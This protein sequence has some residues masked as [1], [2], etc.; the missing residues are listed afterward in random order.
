[1]ELWFDTL[2][3]VLIAVTG[4]FIG[5]F[6]SSV[7]KTYW[8]LSLSIP[9]SIITV[10]AI[11]RFNQSLYFAGPV[12]WIVAGQLRFVVLSFAISLGMT[13]TLSR[14]PHKWEKYVVC[15][16]MVAFL[17]WSSVL[18]F[19]SPALIKG[20]LA[21]IKTRYDKNGICRQTKDY[22][23]GPAAAVTALGKLGLS[24]DEGELAILSHTSPVTGTLPS[25]LCSA[26]QNRFGAD[27][28]K[29][30]FRRFQSIEQLKDTGITLAIIKDTTM[31]DHCVVVLEVADDIVAVADPVTG[32]ELIPY[33]QFEKIWR[34][35][36]IVIERDSQREI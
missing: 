28:L 21:E 29:C 20:Q 23:C 12:F 25:Q 14:L 7:K 18:P 13:I 34:F 24:A 30:Q 32:K 33:E 3:V 9:L 36:G 2:G 8:L 15:T 16:L 22:T 27:G 6:L 1:M 31:V 17:I 11:A 26:L 35:S 10:L 19:L 5:T 4:V